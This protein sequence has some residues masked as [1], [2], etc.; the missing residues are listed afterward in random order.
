MSGKKLPPDRIEYC[1]NH[2]DVRAHA[3]SLCSACYVKKYAAEHADY[4]A[5]SIAR[6]AKWRA[7]NPERSRAITTRYRG[8]L[9]PVKRAD[10][11]LRKKYGITIE[12]YEQMLAEQGGVCFLCNK[13]PAEGK[14]LHVDHCH[15]SG[16]VR[17]LLCS[18]CNWYLGKIDS[19]PSLMERLF[20]Y[21]E[22]GGCHV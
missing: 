3:K 20:C 21:V 13:P 14:K 19:D 1:V 18:Q 10:R 12:Q 9:C 7:D 16:K 15:D 2:P 6:A 4:R 11:N 17:G 5:R 8:K 22:L